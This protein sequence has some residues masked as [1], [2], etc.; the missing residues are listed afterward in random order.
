MLAIADVLAEFPV[1]LLERLTATPVAVG[2][3]GTLSAAEAERGLA[4]G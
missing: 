2:D 3:P 4:R 1:A